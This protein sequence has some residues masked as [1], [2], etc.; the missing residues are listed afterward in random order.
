MNETKR[1]KAHRKGTG[2]L[3]FYSLKVIQIFAKTHYVWGISMRPK[4]LI[5]AAIFLSAFL[6]KTFWWDPETKKEEIQNAFLTKNYPL[7]LE[8]LSKNETLFSPGQTN[9]LLA[10]GYSAL[11]DYKT[12]D[13]KL[14][15]GLYQQENSPELNFEIILNKLLN[16]YLQDDTAALAKYLNQLNSENP[17]AYEWKKLFQGVAALKADKCSMAI[18]I[19]SSPLE[20]E[21]LNPIMLHF[22]SEK[23]PPSWT[24]L[25]IAHCEMSRGN[26]QI[27]RDLIQKTP[28]QY[29]LYEKELSHLLLGK[30]YLL[31]AA[32]MEDTESFPYYLQAI[33]EIETVKEKPQEFDYITELLVNSLQSM[34]QKGLANNATYQIVF[35][36]NAL[37]MLQN[38][39]FYSINAADLN[40]NNTTL[41]AAEYFNQELEQDP[42]DLREPYSEQLIMAETPVSVAII[43][44]ESTKTELSNVEYGVIPA[45]VKLEPQALLPPPPSKPIEKKQ[46]KPINIGSLDE[47][48]YEN[49]LDLNYALVQR[50]IDSILEGE[51]D[52]TESEKQLKEDAAFLTM[53]TQINPPLPPVYF[54]L[55]QV[56]LLLHNFSQASRALSTYVT[57]EPENIWGWRLLALS[58]MG[59]NNHKG[60]INTF[61]EVIKINPIDLA[62]WKS[63]GKIYQSEGNKN[64]AVNAYEKAR[65]MDPFD[66]EIISALDQLYSDQQ[67]Y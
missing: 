42:I 67:G 45:S 8:I 58:Q 38:D 17:L 11:G 52:V 46:H 63:L 31:E 5:I 32:S 9:L 7:F 40:T 18:K 20:L 27:A 28:T 1:Q 41:S 37:N 56:E 30:S 51:R 19:F 47:W 49:P 15:Q 53:L 43:T 59:A 12:A 50:H 21:T 13:I 2:S 65:L 26:Y 61:M 60:A 6:V 22:F 23:L 10:Y 57:F 24:S 66:P 14:S 62:A 44:P 35:F 34:L 33:H 29:S 54:L 36:D 3:F 48:A 4:I 39:G 55:G 64:L 16:A 25:Q